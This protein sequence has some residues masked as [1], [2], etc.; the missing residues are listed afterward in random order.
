MKSIKNYSRILFLSIILYLPLIIK[1]QVTNQT[2][3]KGYIIDAITKKAVPY[4]S[5]VFYNSKNGTYSDNNGYFIL[6]N[7]TGIK[8]IKITSVSYE[9]LEVN[10][11]P[12][13]TQELKI[14]LEAQNT[15]LNEIVVNP[16]KNNYRNKDNPAVEIINNVVKNKDI[17]SN[18]NFDY[19][20]YKKYDKTQ[21]ALSNLSEKFM[22][23]KSLKKFSFIFENIDTTKL[24]GAKILPIYMKETLSNYYYQKNPE[25]SKEII[26]ADKMVSFDGYVNNQGMSEYLNYMYQNI[27][28]YDNTVT[29][30]T[31]IFLS[32]IA[33]SATKF[34]KYYIQDTTFIDG[35]NCVKLFFSP[36]NNTDML[37][38]GFL[39]I[40]L[41]GSF[42]VKKV[43]MSVNKNIN[44]NWVKDVSIIQEFE[45]IQDFGRFI[46]SDEITI[47]FGVSKNSMGIFGQRK[48]IYNNYLINK[49]IPDSIFEETKILQLEDVYEKNNEFWETNRPQEL[50]KSEK[51]IYTITDSIKTIPAFKKTMDM[52][53]LVIAGYKDLGK[54]EIGP[55]NTFYSY[56]PIEGNRLRFGG[57]TTPK[58]SEKINFDTYLAYGFLDK[59]FK[60]YIGTTY[61]LTKNT[62]YHFPVKYLKLSLQNETKIPGQELQFIQEDNIL[63]SIKR[64]VNDKL[65]YDQTIKIE[66]LSEFENHFSY[67]FGYSF[68]KQEPAGSIN[69]NTNDT[70]ILSSDNQYIN[71]SEIYLNLRFAPQEKF[72]QGKQYRTPMTNKYPILNLYYNVGLKTLGNNYNYQNLK[73]NIYKRFYPGIL[74]YTDMIFEAGKIFGEVSYPLLYMHRANQT[75]AYQLA[76]YNLMNFLEFVSDEYISLNVDHHF[77]GFIFNKIPILKK[78]KL[79]EVASGKILYGTLSNTNNPNY[80]ND[81]FKFPVDYEGNPITFTLEK[82]PYVEISVGVEN[83]FKFF[84]V[85]VVKRLTYLNNPNVSDIGIRARFRFDF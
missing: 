71:I 4:A 58:F 12:G 60:Y 55:V 72:Y 28:I 62:I 54:F 10:I 6:T 35:E 61:S 5:I 45:Y 74:G 81:L 9:P 73:I 63:L 41:D 25:K 83:I 67:T 39:Y 22:N 15:K 21:F 40:T 19:L 85:D 14:L 38:N 47:D 56:N 26:N 18:K 24:E 59:Q 76:S 33:N 82:E 1:G 30:V 36:R 53:V 57:R 13:K 51:G 2:I 70:D 46:K 7:N 11:I 69:F 43:D 64:G 23:R 80:D 27:N 37:F 48:V 8:K 20:E 65:F 49:I 3:V 79:R 17:N 29:F 78:L 42:A 84:R 44:Q 75:Y 52:L 50:S 77:N 31:N 34:Y 16:G 66:H 32:P 68:T